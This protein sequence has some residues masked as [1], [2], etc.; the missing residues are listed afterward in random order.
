MP[1]LSNWGF[2]YFNNSRANLVLNWQLHDLKELN[3]NGVC[4]NLHCQI[5][6]S[7]GWFFAMVDRESR[8]QAC[9]GS[10]CC[11]FLNCRQVLQCVIN[12]VGYLTVHTRPIEHI[13]C[14]LLALLYPQVVFMNFVLHCW[15]QWCW[16]NE[17]LS[18]Q[19]K[20]ILQT[21]LILHICSSIVP[22][23]E[24]HFRLV[25]WPSLQ[26]GFLKFLQWLVSLR[27]DPKLF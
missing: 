22:Y 20:P 25:V 21:D 17:S 15:S 18:F 26:H 16:H 10:F 12:E 6:T 27:L 8:V 1:Y 7:P 2:R 9:L 19:K 4:S 13:L 23:A 24:V 14:S 5:Q 3:I 11:A